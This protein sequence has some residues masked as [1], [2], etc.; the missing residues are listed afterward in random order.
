M[1]AR[2]IKKKINELLVPKVP[3]VPVH[4]MYQQALGFDKVGGD[5]VQASEKHVQ[6][7]RDQL[8]EAERTHGQLVERKSVA[9]KVKAKLF[10][11]LQTVKQPEG[12]VVSVGEQA[13]KEV[14]A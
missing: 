8:A 9:E 12:P 5:K 11:K 4:K 3:E 7:M 13:A 14:E 10:A 2:D 1:A 6:K